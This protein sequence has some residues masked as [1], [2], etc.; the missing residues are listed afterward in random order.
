MGDPLHE[1]NFL[2]ASLWHNNTWTYSTTF[3]LSEV[4]KATQTLLV[5]DGELPH[6]LDFDA[7][8]AACRSIELTLA[9]VKMA[10]RVLV[11]GVLVG[12]TVDQYLRYVFPLS[13]AHLLEG[14]PS[15]D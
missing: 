3:S 2:A 13:S 15:L 9:G 11:N 8:F 1:L 6:F 14:M 10:A 5:F 12:T 7:L 4:S